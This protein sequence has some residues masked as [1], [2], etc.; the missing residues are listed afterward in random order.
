MTDLAVCQR[1]TSDRALRFGQGQLPRSSRVWTPVHTRRHHATALA[2][3]GSF[4]RVL[5]AVLE[6]EGRS[7]RVG[8]D[9]VRTRLCSSQG[10]DRAARDHL[11]TA[12]CGRGLLCR[13]PFAKLLC[14]VLSSFGRRAREIRYEGCGPPIAR[15]T[16][17]RTLCCSCH[18]RAFLAS[19]DSA[20]LCTAL[21]GGQGLVMPLS[22]LKSA[23]ARPH[24][25]G[26]TEV[27][28][29]YWTCAILCVYAEMFPAARLFIRATATV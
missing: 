6:Q 5:P 24:L 7:F 19:R 25:P 9:V 13:H 4:P 3:G 27:S 2:V 22:R 21:G 26:R 16:S 11:Q 10:M 29:R 8:R 17:A 12:S 28:F 1:N 18:E 20:L 23:A 14:I 15:C